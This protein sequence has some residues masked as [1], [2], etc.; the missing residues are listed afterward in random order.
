MEFTATRT[1]TT[2]LP[3]PCDQLLLLLS[4]SLFIIHHRRPED[5]VLCLICCIARRA[6]AANI[7]T[8]GRSHDSSPLHLLKQHD[9]AWILVALLAICHD[10]YDLCVGNNVWLSSCCSIAAVCLMLYVCASRRNIPLHHDTISLVFGKLVPVE[11]LFTLTT[12][13]AVLFTFTTKVAVLFA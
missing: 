8:T 3:A 6:D 5:H 2:T 1:M 11:M 13:V 7:V 10:D 4:S 9:R 12:N